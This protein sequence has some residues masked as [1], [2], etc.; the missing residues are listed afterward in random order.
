MMLLFSK[1]PAFNQDIGGWNV[2]GVINMGYMFHGATAFNQDIGGWNVSN[3]TDMS[4]IFDGATRFNQDIGGWNVSSVT[5]MWM[6]FSR[7][8]VFNQ[9][10]SGWKVSSVTDM[11]YMF[12]WT[13]VFNQDI[14]GWNV[15]SVT[16]MRL[17]FSGATVFNQDISGWNVSSVANMENMFR[18]VTLA[19]EN[20]DSLLI[21]WGNL[22]LQSGVSFSAGN[23]MY[24]SA[25]TSARQYIIDTY[26]WTIIDDGLILPTNPPILITL[27]QTINYNNITVQWNTQNG[28]DYY[29][30][31]VGGLLNETT[32][33]IEQKVM[34]WINGT[35]TITV[36]AVNALG[37]SELS[38]E[39]II[40]V[41][42]PPEIQ[43]P[44]PPTITTSTQT[45]TI[46]SITIHWDEVTYATSYNVYINGVFSNNTTSLQQE[47]IMWTN[48]IYAVTVTAVNEAGESDFSNE[49]VITVEISE[50]Y[51]PGANN[52]PVI[53]SI[54]TGVAVIV[55]IILIIKG[56][57][58]E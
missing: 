13:D 34:L 35:Y 27:N 4:G 26:G 17:M 21:E 14:G 9:D 19:T 31:Y 48:G 40:I 51:D 54:I 47:F 25:A 1:A 49:I 46:D 2:S 32:T 10:I 20:Y 41:E 29:N 56:R 42:I 22:S 30:V 52:D 53:V 44:E 7:A 11:G 55:I 57:K 5:N 37:E 18:N 24:S 23:S 36:T 33:I 58:L 45:I 50:E 3:V 16:D 38:N 43:E 6:M 15:S 12:S 8:D 28:T 39:I